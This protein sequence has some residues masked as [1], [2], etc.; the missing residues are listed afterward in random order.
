[1]NSDA[2]CLLVARQHEQPDDARKHKRAENRRGAEIFGMTG[3][4]VELAADPID[5]GFNRRIDN[6]DDQHEKPNAGEQGAFDPVAPKP[7]SERYH[8]QRKK[9]FVAQSGL[10]MPCS[11]Q[12]LEGITRRQQDRADEREHDCE[13]SGERDPTVMGGCRVVRV[14]FAGFSR[15]AARTFSAVIGSDLMRTPT[16]SSTALAIAAAVGISAVSP[17]LMLLYGPLPKS[18]CRIAV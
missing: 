6:F 11:A 15:N 10:T 7:T 1:M 2:S 12:A 13:I 8:Q 9:N 16:A 14:Q 18:D 5:D 3:K 4:L 17:M